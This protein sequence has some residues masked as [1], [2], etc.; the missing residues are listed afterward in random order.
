MKVVKRDKRSRLRGQRR[1][2][3][4]FGKKHRGKGSKG[5]KGMAGTGKRAGHKRTF[6]DKFMP[7]Y[8]GKHG[9]KSIQQIK[10]SKPKII[11]IAGIIRQ[12]NALIAKGTAKKTASGTEISLPEFKI[13]GEGEV[14]EKLVIKAMSAS[15]QAKEKI[16]KAG[17]KI[18]TED[19]A[20][21]KAKAE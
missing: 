11:N 16:E 5:G 1:C 2:G 13:L 19:N 14:K 20:F 3:Y 10:N 21:A 6:I 18:I 8:F 7:D 15:S 4:G 17:G 9:F 12:L